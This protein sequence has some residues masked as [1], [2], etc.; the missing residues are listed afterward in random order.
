MIALQLRKMWG[1]T[2]I[3]RVGSICY[4]RCSRE[5]QEGK[6]DSNLQKV[7]TNIYKWE[8]LD[9]SFRK[10]HGNIP[11]LDGD[12]NDEITEVIYTFVTNFDEEAVLYTMK[13]LL[14]FKV[15][16][17]SSSSSVDG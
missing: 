4:C 17:Q 6:C 8:R 5:C 15:G 14:E 11:Q 16:S 1:F 13:E 2:N 12:S 9:V 3:K 7:A 10:T